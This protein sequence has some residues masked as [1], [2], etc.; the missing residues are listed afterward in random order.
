VHAQ[1][2]FWPALGGASMMSG[3]AAGSPPATRD[4]DAELLAAAARGDGDAFARLVDR[5]L[6]RLHGLAFRALGVRAEAEDVTQETLLR[7]W[8]QLPT[9]KPGDAQFSTWL[10][11]VALNLVNDRLRARREQVPVDEVALESGGP[12]PEQLESQRQREARVRVAL[13]QLPE[14]QRDAMLLCHF[15]GLGNIEAA[16]ALEVSVDALESL[17]ARARRGLRALLL[18]NDPRDD[19]LPQ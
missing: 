13:Q 11:R 12:G 4:P 1:A 19:S 15:E 10:Q 5:H 7:A 9:W 8:R 14:R 2:R 16:A 6:P 17:L 3:R 18:D